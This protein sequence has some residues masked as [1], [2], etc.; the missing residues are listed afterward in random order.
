MRHTGWTPDQ[1]REMQPA[2]QRPGIKLEGHWKALPVSSNSER[3]TLVLFIERS[4]K[5]GSHLDVARCLPIDYIIRLPILRFDEARAPTTQCRDG[6]CIRPDVPEI[7]FDRGRAFLLQLEMAGKCLDLHGRQ[8]VF[9]HK[10]PPFV[11]SQRYCTGA[12]N[13]TRPTA[14]S[15]AVGLSVP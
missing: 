10:E 13:I 9:G 15:T 2:P 5:S 4:R 7:F 6:D 3:W 1:E 11:I 8:C 12:A 14:A